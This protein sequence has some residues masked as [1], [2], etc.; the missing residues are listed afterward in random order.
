[1][2]ILFITPG[3]EDYLADSLL[4]GLRSLYGPDCVDYPKAEHMYAGYEPLMG[5]RLYGCG[6]TLYSG[7]LDDCPVDRSL[8]ETKVRNGFFDRIIF[9]DI[10]NQYGLFAQWRPYLRPESTVICDGADSPQAYPYAGRWWRRPSQWLAPRAHRD[11]PYFKREWTED[12]QFN[13]WHRLLPRLLRKRLPAHPNLRKI[14]F[15]IPKEKIIKALPQKTKDF[16]VHCVDPEV[17][18]EIPDC[19]TAY[20]FENEA[21]YYAD[22][23][24]SRFAITTKRAG[25]DCMRHYEI[26][27]NGCVPCFRHL[28]KKSASCA[29]HGLDRSNCI[30][31]QNFNDMIRQIEALS[32]EEE[33]ALRKAV[34]K[35]AQLSSSTKVAKGLLDRSKS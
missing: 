15:S 11:F 19:K 5:S 31:Y 24:A 6:F 28:G 8:I 20:A 1:M 25:W 2:K 12:T 29:P 26:A 30:I 4:H 13:L 14:N 16:A 3:K 23:Q 17:A 9:G 33:L 18:A 32:S 34:F 7:L 35:W 22:L 21:E 10:W 27:A